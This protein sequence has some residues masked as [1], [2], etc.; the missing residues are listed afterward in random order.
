MKAGWSVSEWSEATSIGRTKVFELISHGDVDSV[1]SGRRRIIITQPA[2]Y[3]ARLVDAS[4]SD[5]AA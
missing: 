2:E 1:T 3:L 4:R 5:A